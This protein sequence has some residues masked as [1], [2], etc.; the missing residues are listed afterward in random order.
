MNLK[1]KKVK[2]CDLNCVSQ[3]TCRY[4]YISINAV[5]NNIMLHVTVIVM[6]FMS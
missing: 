6:V 5:V 2:H 4:T 3:G 1:I